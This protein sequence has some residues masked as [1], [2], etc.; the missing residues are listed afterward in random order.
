MPDTMVSGLV[1]IPVLTSVWQILWNFLPP[2]RLPGN[3]VI[4]A[5]TES[6]VSA[7]AMPHALHK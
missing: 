5:E 6:E 3:V 1:M 4:I 2:A 7:L